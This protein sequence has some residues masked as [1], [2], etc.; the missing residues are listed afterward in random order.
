MRKIDKIDLKILNE[1][2]KNSSQPLSK[3]GKNVRLSRENV[4]YRIQ[5]L[6]KDKVIKNFVVDISAKKLGF[7]QYVVFLEFERINKADEEKIISYL[8]SQKNISWI[9]IL[10]GKWSLTFDIYV[11]SVDE[12]NLIV[13]SILNKFSKEVGDY[14]VLELLD[15]EYF[16]NKL[17][18]TSRVIHS[19]INSEK[20][21]YDKRDIKILNELNKNS[22][23][24][25]FEIS[26]Q[27]KISPNTVKNRI[28]AM[29]KEGIIG[30]YSASINHK[31][32]GYEWHG[33]QLKL[34]KPTN[35][36]E[37]KVISYIKN[38]PKII[39]YYKYVKSGFYDFDIGVI[40][41]DSTELRNFINQLR[42]DFFEQ[43]KIV[44]TFLVLEESSSHNLPQAI[45]E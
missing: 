36:V 24:S 29:E 7:S 27:L 43:I 28:K 9:G 1:L 23:K 14:L 5:K 15:S 20:Q 8:K 33:L 12:L 2:L 39:F 22:R 16:F 6:M 11:R 34:T 37:Q 40:I 4:H 38:N 25:Y 44:D 26:E 19:K 17:I 21:R 13:S 41:R 18:N 42:T 32:F 45:F 10:S 31:S 3:I 30:G 35:E